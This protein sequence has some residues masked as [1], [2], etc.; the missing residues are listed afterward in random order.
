[1][2]LASSALHG[3]LE[4]H[5]VRFYCGVPD[6]LL[7]DFCAYV[8]ETLPKEQH[9]I[10]PNEGSAVAIA[11]GHTLATGAPALVY[12]QNSGLGN[13]INPLTSLA[14][15]DVYG[16]PM[17]LLIGWRGEPGK[18][19]EPQH[20]R[21]GAFSPKV[22]EA[23]DV[24]WQELSPEADKAEAQVKAA[25]ETA[26]VQHRP[27]ALLVRKGTFDKHKSAKKLQR[28]FEM[29]RE[30]AINLVLDAIPDDAAMVSTTGKT[31]REVFELRVARKESHERDMLTV[32]SM[33]HCSQIALGIA[34]AQP[35]REVWCLDGDGA[36]IMHLG[37][38]T[39]VATSGGAHFRHVL[40]NNG[41]HDSV[42]GQPTVALDC[43][44]V[45][46]AKA[47]GYRH[48]ATVATAAELP[49][50]L[51]AFKAAEGPAF[52]EV[53][54]QIGARDDLG[55]PTRTPGQAKEAFMAFLRT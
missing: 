19:D 4:Q 25:L 10:A 31:S 26:V 21:M 35:K 16:I 38:L 15:K 41:A 40:F 48:A 39:S 9:V 29:T 37:G 2:S 18:K 20:M 49:E 5:G 1:M 55:R 42:G 17:V 53:K 52:L 47:S 54:V 51:A 44:L 8:A 24:P 36:A 13:T 30:Q 27:V 14:D 43:D 33:G 45:A 7:K 32:G 46:M 22:L 50:A 34:L 11:A 23:I 6:S 28:P 3:F 12:L